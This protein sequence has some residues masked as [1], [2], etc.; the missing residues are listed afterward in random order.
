VR[1]LAD[2]TERERQA[3]RLVAQGFRNKEIAARMGISQS[4]LK[5][6]VARCF[7][8]AGVG[9]RVELT[10]WVLDQDAEAN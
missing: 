6:Y 3:A 5:E 8:K 7:I 4:T 9:N 2:L 10:L 1:R